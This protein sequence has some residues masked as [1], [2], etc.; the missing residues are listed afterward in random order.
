MLLLSGAFLNRSPV[1]VPSE[2]NMEELPATSESHHI[3]LS[4]GNASKDKEKRPRKLKLGL[5][6]LFHVVTCTAFSFH[7]SEARF[8]ALLLRSNAALY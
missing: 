1:S 7:F 4:E 5:S 8:W 2:H 6:A 3:L